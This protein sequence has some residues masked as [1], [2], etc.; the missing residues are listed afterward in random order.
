VTSQQGDYYPCCVR[1]RSVI[2][3]VAYGVSD[4]TGSVV[5]GTQLEEGYEYGF[6]I[7]SG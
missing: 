6:R 1:G 3:I 2:Q 4:K 7:M 5:S